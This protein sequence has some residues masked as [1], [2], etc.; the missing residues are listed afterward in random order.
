MDDDEKEQNVVPLRLLLGG[1]GGLPDNVLAAKMMDA[2]RKDQMLRALQAIY[3]LVTAGRLET[4]CIIAR[5][6]K[7]PVGTG[8]VMNV[9]VPADYNSFEVQ[10]MLNATL[11]FEVQKLR[12]ERPDPEPPKPGA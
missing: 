8:S 2:H 12:T 10:G 1:G 5:E 11:H 6:K 7:P 4:L 9:I 3:D